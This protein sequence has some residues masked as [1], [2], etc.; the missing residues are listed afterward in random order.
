M[1]AADRELKLRGYEVFHFGH[2]E[3][4]RL[5]AAQALLRQFLPAM[6]RRFRVSS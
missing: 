2:E 5:D 6:F 4:R 1:V 3:L